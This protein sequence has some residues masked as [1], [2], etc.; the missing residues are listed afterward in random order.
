M[1][2]DF[3]GADAMLSNANLDFVATSNAIFERSGR[4]AA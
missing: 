2:E 3:A 1:A 4:E